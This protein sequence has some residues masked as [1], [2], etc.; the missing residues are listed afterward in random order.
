MIARNRV[1][2][3]RR[4]LPAPLGPVYLGTWILLTLARRPS[5]AALRAWF[6]GFR[7]GG[8]PLRSAPPDALAYGLADDQAGPTAGHLII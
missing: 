7:E 4:N 8:R 5:V 1:W 2:L 6:G 3:A